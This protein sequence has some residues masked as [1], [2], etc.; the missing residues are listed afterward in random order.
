MF[1]ERAALIAHDHTCSGEGSANASV[2]SRSGGCFP[3]NTNVGQKASSG[4]VGF[5]QNR[6]TL[7]AVVADA[8]AADEHGRFGGEPSEGGGE[9]RGALGP[10]IPN[11]LFSVVGPPLVANACTSEMYHG[12]DA[13]EAGRVDGAARW[14][15]LDLVGTCLCSPSD[16]SDWSVPL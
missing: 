14:I 15:P 6:V 7:A 3:L 1:L 11:D 2:G 16:Q 8:A 4:R 10:A 12:V 5:G 13:F 9:H